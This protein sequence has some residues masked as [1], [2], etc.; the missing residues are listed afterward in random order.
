MSITVHD[1]E[2]RYSPQVNRFF[3]VRA[4][5]DDYL[6]CGSFTT[7]YETAMTIAT[8]QPLSHDFVA[9]T[10]AIAAIDKCPYAVFTGTGWRV[11]ELEDEAQ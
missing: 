7:Y 6:V 11:R 4:I 5:H 1:G 3:Q 10:E 2:V 9:S 8:T